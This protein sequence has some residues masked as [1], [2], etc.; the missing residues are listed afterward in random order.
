MKIHTISDLHFEFD[1]KMMKGYT[2]PVDADVVVL[3]GDIAPGVSGVKWAANTFQPTPT[4]YV[5]GNHEFYGANRYL[6]KGY[7]KLREAAEGTNVIVLQNDTVVIDGIR[8]IGTTLW[9]DMA[10]YGNQPLMM[11]QAQG[12]MNDY[13]HIMS[14]P[15]RG[16]NWS[17]R[18]L[19]PVETVR[20]HELAMEFL[21]DELNQE[22]DGPT[23]VVTHHAP[24][25]QSCL[26]EFAGNPANP[27][28]ASNLDRFVEAMNPALWIH[29]H[30]HQSKD[31][32]IGETRIVANPRGYYG[33]VV[34]VNFDPALILEV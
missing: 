21:T 28:Y 10:L 25:E 22:Y 32:M 12:M 19:M 31:Y 30:T 20:E 6:S 26:P 14:E 29:G 3:A 18:P 17:N 11:I 24:S 27:L 34:N 4:I 16:M 15:P 23:V 9:T 8:F 1:P 2:P 13:R 7:R 33:D 5:G